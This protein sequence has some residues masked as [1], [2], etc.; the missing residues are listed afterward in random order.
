MRELTWPNGETD[1][2]AVAD[3]TT[4]TA[5]TF[6]GG[7]QSIRLVEF[8]LRSTPQSRPWEDIAHF[9][10]PA[11]GGKFYRPVAQ[12]VVVRGDSSVLVGMTYE[13]SIG[14]SGAFLGAT[15]LSVSQDQLVHVLLKRANL[16][17]A[18][19]QSGAT[20]IQITDS[21]CADGL[22]AFRVTANGRI[23][24][25]HLSCAAWMQSLP[26][27]HVEFTINPRTRVLS[28]PTPVVT[29]HVGN[30]V[31]FV[32]SPGYTA[33][34]ANK[35]AIQI[36]SNAWNGGAV[37]YS[38]SDM[39]SAPLSYQFRAV[40]NYQFVIFGATQKSLTIQVRVVE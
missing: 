2:V 31:V 22:Y 25:E 38:M 35:G 34:Q 17:D 14:A 37:N 32:P 20:G 6:P 27:T 24:S 3:E 9:S 5:T 26:G 8:V 23:T 13:I 40:G 28:S 15:V 11:E 18:G 29:V 33:A 7:T 36:Y 30:T 10:L 12:W 21:S 1:V 4:Y 16:Y 19:I 39:L